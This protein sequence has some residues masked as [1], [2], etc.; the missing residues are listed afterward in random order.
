MWRGAAV[1]I[2]YKDSVAPPDSL[3]EK[4]F[5]GRREGPAQLRATIGKIKY[6]N[7]ISNHFLPNLYF[8]YP[9]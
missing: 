6:G 9:Q 5:L 3:V 7:G 4:I 2:G 1:F 8:C